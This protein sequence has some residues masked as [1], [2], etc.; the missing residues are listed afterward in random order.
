MPKT[1]KRMHCLFRKNSVCDS[2]LKAKR[3]ANLSLSRSKVLLRWKLKRKVGVT[4]LA[5]LKKKRPSVNGFFSEAVAE[6]TPKWKLNARVHKAWDNSIKC[7]PSSGFKASS[8][9]TYKTGDCNMPSVVEHHQ[10][11]S[12]DHFVDTT[13]SSCF[14][15][16]IIDDSS[17][18]DCSS[19]AD[20]TNVCNTSALSDACDSQYVD[21]FVGEHGKITHGEG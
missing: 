14:S 21:S 6:S 16:V 20:T 15:P 4:L 9:N 3:T 5:A 18:V 11:D 1:K 19:A 13:I 8:S 10:N 12:T 2:S 17:D 7:R